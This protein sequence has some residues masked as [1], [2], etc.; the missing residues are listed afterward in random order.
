M[1]LVLLVI[2]APIAGLVCVKL[3]REQ[4]LDA[5]RYGLTG[6]ALSLLFLLPWVYLISRMSGIR[7]SR[8]LTVLGYVLL[9]GFW[10]WVPLIGGMPYIT[11]GQFADSGLGTILH[12]E[13]YAELVKWL[14]ILTWLGS[15]AWVIY[16]AD[17]EAAKADKWW[18]EY[19]DSPLIP[20]VGYVVPFGLGVFWATVVS[21]G[22]HLP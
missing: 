8:T 11:S 13:T 1:A 21:I 19:T 18:D 7:P 16:L 22:V 3:A 2:G 12:V 17:R 14:C 4:G 10:L 20:K 6:A 5:R 9:Y 15:A